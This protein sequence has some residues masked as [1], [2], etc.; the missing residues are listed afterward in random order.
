LRKRYEGVVWEDG[1]EMDAAWSLE[2]FQEHFEPFK[3][4]RKHLYPEEFS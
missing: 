3:T 1:K 4:N 2:E